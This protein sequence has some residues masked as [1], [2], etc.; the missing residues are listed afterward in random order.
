MD[1]AER[2]QALLL[3]LTTKSLKNCTISNTFITAGNYHKLCVILVANGPQA[4]FP[5]KIA[6]VWCF[7][8]LRLNTKH[9]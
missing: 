7:L 8:V 4:G 5:L 1:K 6:V 2:F 3:L 9:L